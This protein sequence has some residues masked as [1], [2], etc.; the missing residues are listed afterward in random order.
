M[1]Q[2]EVMVG[3]LTMTLIFAGQSRDTLI[4]ESPVESNS[5][6]GRMSSL[7]LLVKA[8]RRMTNKY[9]EKK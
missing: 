1:Q 8:K 9:V 7:P 6:Q 3:H 4:F 2:A 5:G